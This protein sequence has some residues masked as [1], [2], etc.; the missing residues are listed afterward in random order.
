M[1]QTVEQL[2]VIDIPKIRADIEL[3]PISPSTEK[4]SNYVTQH[5]LQHNRYTDIFLPRKKL[6]Q[7]A[8]THIKQIL[9]N[10]LEYTHQV[11]HTVKFYKLCT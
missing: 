6:L 3:T 7:F 11:G 9:V 2:V 4:I 10:A 1:I 8:C 5:M